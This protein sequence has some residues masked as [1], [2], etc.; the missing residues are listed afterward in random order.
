MSR[1]TRIIL[2]TIVF[3][4]AV[5]LGYLSAQSV[6]AS[7]IID[8]INNGKNVSLENT[9]IRGDLDL[10]KLDNMR[11]V[12]KDGKQKKY[13]SEVRVELRFI[14]CTF[15]GEVQAYI[16]NEGNWNDIKSK[17]LYTAN[18]RESVT[19]AN[20]TFE[21]DA[22]FKYSEFDQSAS[23]QG[24]E[25]KDEALFKYAEF[26]EAADFSNVRFREANFKYT[27]FQES[28]TFAN[29]RYRGD[30]IYKYTEFT[31]GVT[32]ADAVFQNDASFKYTELRREVS[33]AGANFEG[34]ADFKYIKFPAGTDLTNTSFGRYT[35]FKYATLGGKKFRR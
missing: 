5:G 10:T 26:E 11:Q 18:F 17:P 35:D 12:G 27:K 28:I 6:N 15:T 29:C 9:T 23:F 7:E 25:F 14:G 13:L 2:L 19:F 32:F 30:A 24:S 16:P 3:L 31:D 21:E 34:Q 33:F 20:C 1:I 22:L 8:M 4:V